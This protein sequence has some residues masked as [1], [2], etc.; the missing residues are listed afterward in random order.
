MYRK[1][2]SLRKDR[3]IFRHTAE[4]MNSVNIYDVIPRGGTRM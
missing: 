3:R 1:A 4:R 2:M